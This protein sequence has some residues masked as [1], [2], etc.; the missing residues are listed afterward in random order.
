[1][2]F[3]KIHY[4][5]KVDP[6]LFTYDIKRT[7]KYDDYMNEFNDDF[8]EPWDED[9]VPYEIGDHI[10]EHFHF[11]NGRTKWPTCSS[12]EDGFYNGGELPGMKTFKNF[13]ELDYELLEK[14]QD[15]WWKVNEHECSLFANWRN[16]IRRPYANYYSNFLDM[17]KHKE[18]ERCKVFDDHKRTVC[19]IRRLEMVKYSFR[20]D[21]E[22]VAIKE[23]KYNDL[24]NTSKEGIHAYQEI[25][26]IMD[27]GWMVTRTE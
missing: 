16:Y 6:E 21:E 8:E 1:M 26:R 5:L 9:G 13:H 3:N 17:M 10:C 24:T 25:F 12:N 4:L 23:K 7:E 20:D 27:E 18:E 14:L 22:Y 2:A 19:Y 11:K 15:Y